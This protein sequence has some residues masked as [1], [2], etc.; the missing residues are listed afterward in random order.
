MA[1]RQRQAAGQAGRL[2]GVD[3]AD[4][5]TD[6]QRRQKSIRCHTKAKMYAM[7]TATLRLADIEQYPMH[8]HT[9][10]H[11]VLTNR[12]RDVY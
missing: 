5:T 9:H 10:T 2:A 11:L 6:E 1:V 12:T 4:F 7:M 3:V 8:T